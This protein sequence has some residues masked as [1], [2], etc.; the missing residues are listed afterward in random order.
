MVGHL[1]IPEIAHGVM[2]MGIIRIKMRMAIIEAK[3]VLIATELVN[4]N[5]FRKSVSR[6]TICNG[7]V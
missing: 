2:D 5:Q 6:E 7:F 3:S 1:E 4:G